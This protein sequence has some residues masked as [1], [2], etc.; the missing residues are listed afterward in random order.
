MNN[1][2]FTQE[3]R[4][5]YS[6]DLLRQ[7][8]RYLLQTFVFIGSSLFVAIIGSDTIGDKQWVSLVSEKLF[9]YVGPDSVFYLY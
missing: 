3:I 1:N 2:F 9:A 6:F 7:K 8:K 4:V 5:S